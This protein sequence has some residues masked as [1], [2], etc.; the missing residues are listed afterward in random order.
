MAADPDEGQRQSAAS[1]LHQKRL[2]QRRQLFMR[3]ALSKRPLHVQ[4]TKSKA[5]I[6]IQQ[7][8]HSQKG[9][10]FRPLQMEFETVQWNG[11]DLELQ[12]RGGLVRR[13][14][15]LQTGHGPAKRVFEKEQ[16][17]VGRVQVAV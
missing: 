4:E 8:D 3:I 9:L 1:F 17:K 16:S 13:R 11:R 10:G 12:I 2:F 5:S 15:P 6:H 7:F 14:V